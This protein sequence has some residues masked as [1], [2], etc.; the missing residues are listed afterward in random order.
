[1][2]QNL[3]K[4]SINF[5]LSTGRTGST[6]LSSM[7]N[8]HSEILSVSEEPFAYNL[9]PKYKDV[10]NWDDQKI[11]EFCY[12][13]YLFS[14]GKLEPQFGTKQDL[15]NILK[16]H[17]SILTGEKAIKLAYFAFFPN[18]DKSKVNTIVDKELKFHHFLAEVAAFYPNSKF[19]VLSRDPR[20]NVLIKI[21]RAIKKKKRISTV[22][23]AK[24]WNYEYKTLHDKISKLDSS[25]YI[26]V[27]YEDLVSEPEKELKKITSFLNLG[28]QE[29]MLNYDEKFK[30]EVKRNESIIGET[31]KQHLTMFHEGLTQKTNTKKI[32]I[33][34]S[35]LTKS[36]ND[37]IWTI[38][39]D[40]AEKY[41]YFAEGC[42]K[43]FYLRFYMLFD[44]VRFYF[45][46]ILVPNI[47]YNLPYRIKYLIKK[48]KYGKNL[49][50]GTWTTKDFYKTTLPK[51]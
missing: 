23:L 49:K 30:E 1:M 51:N 38:C 34:K 48:I 37:K 27:K 14:E 31:V 3:D 25:R 40:V 9:Y 5:I 13:F 7:L 6:L 10:T 44:I 35:E 41:N 15:I 29:E 21:K 12:D 17:K 47:Y 24:N 32:G 16:E 18:K 36:Q 22:F 42:E 11:E 26:K 20:D 43:R 50:N 45:D 28:Y 19:I 39:G 8:M 46:K 2:I 4:I 33:W